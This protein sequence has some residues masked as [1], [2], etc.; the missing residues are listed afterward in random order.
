[1]S[2]SPKRKRPTPVK[3]KAYMDRGWGKINYLA[4]TGRTSIGVVLFCL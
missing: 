3:E 4:S 2:L 1:M